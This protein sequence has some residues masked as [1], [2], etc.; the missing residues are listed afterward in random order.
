MD[1]YL[2]LE[3]GAVFKG[4]FFGFPRE[5]A[6]EVVFSTGMVGYPE[7]LTDP[8]FKSQI[9]VFTYPLI[10]NYG[11][12]R[13]RRRHQLIVNFESKRIHAAGVVVTCQS[14][15]ASHWAARLSFADWL[16]ENK[17]PGLSNI[18]T[19]YLTQKLRQ[20]GVMLGKL[21]FKKPPQKNLEFYDPNRENLAG[22]VSCSRPIKYQG[23]KKRILLIDCGVKT[24]IIKSLLQLKITVI[25]VPWNFD[26]FR[27]GLRFDAVVVSNGPGDARK[28][29]ETIKT[30]RKIL[31]NNIPFLGICLGNQILALAVGGKIYK[32]K[33]GHHSQ[34]QPCLLKGTQKAFVTSQN[35]GY[36]VRASSLPH[37]WK[38]WF[39]NLNDGSNEGIIHRKKPFASIQFHPEA[40]PGPVDTRFIFEEFLAWIR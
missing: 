13:P 17:T 15:S 24:S 4:Q 11:L 7:S 19:R 14:K 21:V 37:E 31:E 22:K 35:H 28:L 27:D 40:S 20:K 25:Q 9:I 3:D 18:D 36:A 12:P 39:F 26:P 30:V 38:E 33:Y 34:N 23:G 10:G 5:V 6:G 1:G 32:M 16:K 29:P 8:S 2:V